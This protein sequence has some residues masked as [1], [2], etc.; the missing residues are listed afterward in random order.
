MLGAAVQKDVRV[1]WY[2]YVTV[3]GVISPGV[4]KYRKFIDCLTSSIAV[5]IIPTPF[6][7]STKTIVNDITVS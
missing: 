7:S 1:P 3:L 2:L 6:D 4:V 5:I